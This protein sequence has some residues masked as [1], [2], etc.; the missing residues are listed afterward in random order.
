MTVSKLSKALKK[1]NFK[2]VLEFMTKKKP[3]SGAVS[4]AGPIR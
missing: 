2:A 4:E 3:E 1:P